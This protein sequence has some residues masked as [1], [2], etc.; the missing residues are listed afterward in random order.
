MVCLLGIK[1]KVLHPWMRLMRISL[2]LFICFVRDEV[3]FS[4]LHISALDRKAVF[5]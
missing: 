5:E 2:G 3:I 1:V 4:A